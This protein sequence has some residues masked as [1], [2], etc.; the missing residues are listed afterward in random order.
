MEAAACECACVS[1]SNCLIPDIFTHNHDALLTNNP[2]EMKEYLKYLLK[3]PKDRIRLGKNARQT[4]L[5]RFGKSR[6]T[7]QWND[8]FF[9]MKDVVKV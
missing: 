4:V 3:N 8:L 9:K 2:L 5:D 1:T 6:F 7:K